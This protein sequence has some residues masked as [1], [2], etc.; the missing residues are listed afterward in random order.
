MAKRWIRLLIVVLF[1]IAILYCISVFTSSNRKTLSLALCN[2][3]L[4]F[5]VFEDAE[6][7]SFAKESYLDIKNEL[8]EMKNENLKLKFQVKMQGESNG[9]HD[10]TVPPSDQPKSCA[11]VKS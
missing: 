7:T 8:L 4:I 10:A 9:N 1:G 3:C 2:C 5:L 6:N 11:N